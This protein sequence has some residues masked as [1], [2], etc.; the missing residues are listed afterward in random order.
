MRPTTL[1]LLLSQTAPMLSICKSPRTDLTAASSVGET[2][3]AI[4]V[5]YFLRVHTE[6]VLVLTQLPP[7]RYER[8]YAGR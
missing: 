1:L 3:P 5:A 8:L 2:E 4:D 7:P 6:A